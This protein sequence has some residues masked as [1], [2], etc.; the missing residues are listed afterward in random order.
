MEYDH[1]ECFHLVLQI[2]QCE[3][4]IG[5]DCVHKQ[6]LRPFRI[7]YLFYTRQIYRRISNLRITRE[8][9]ERKSAIAITLIFVDIVLIA[10]IYYSNPEP[11]ILIISISSAP[12]ISKAI[13]WNLVR[14]LLTYQQLYLL[15]LK[16][17]T[18]SLNILTILKIS[19]C[20]KEHPLI[21]T[22]Y[23]I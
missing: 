20:S 5:T 1:Q 21:S 7:H 14:Q 10:N 4:R 3:M 12:L 22:I 13:R 11:S 8:R 18:L 6:S 19:G 9:Y 23:N 16:V 15:F 2:T 17:S